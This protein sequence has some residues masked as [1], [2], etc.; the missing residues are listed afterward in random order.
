[1]FGEGGNMLLAPLGA[2][3]GVLETKSKL[4]VHILLLMSED[5]G[6]F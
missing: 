6:S 4:A 5:D 3:M 1:M 2:R